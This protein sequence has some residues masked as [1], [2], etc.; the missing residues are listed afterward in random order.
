LQTS[1]NKPP[2]TETQDTKTQSRIQQ[3]ELTL[4]SPV[5]VKIE[6]LVEEAVEAEDEVERRDR[7]EELKDNWT[8]KRMKETRTE[9]GV[10][11]RIQ[12]KRDKLLNRYTPETHRKHL[13]TIQQQLRT[14][15]MQARLAERRR[16]PEKAATDDIPANRDS[17]E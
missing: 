9:D 5:T 4:N 1:G 10:P 8:Q 12:E 6:G 14:K 3:P 2:P 17:A 11:T 16:L 13:S 7:F 15:K